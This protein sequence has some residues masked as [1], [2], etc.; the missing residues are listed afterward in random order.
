[1]RIK[2]T[3]IHISVGRN[4]RKSIRRRRLKDYKEMLF[5]FNKA[6]ENY[7]QQLKTSPSGEIIIIFNFL[8]D[9]LLIV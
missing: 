2:T 1:M 7:K 9:T 6:V 3:T 4:S 5:R 8:L